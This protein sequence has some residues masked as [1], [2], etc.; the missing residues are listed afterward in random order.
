MEGGNGRKDHADNRPAVRRYSIVHAT[1][2]GELVV[3]SV[4]QHKAVHRRQEIETQI[5]EATH[6]LACRPH[7][8][9]QRVVGALNV[10]GGKGAVR[11]RE[12]TPSKRPTRAPPAPN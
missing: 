8:Y 3:V 10:H 2:H 1:R 7:L 12:E 4:L 9:G 6:T 11:I 5:V